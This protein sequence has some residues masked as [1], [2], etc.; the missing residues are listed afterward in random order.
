[1]AIT[2]RQFIE[3]AA[4]SGVPA[5]LAVT[6][7][8]AQA[9]AVSFSVPNVGRG[10]RAIVVGAGISGLI[11]ALELGRA[12]FSCTIVEASDRIGGRVL[13][14]RGGDQV[15]E[16]GPVQIAQWGRK[17]HLYFNAGASRIS[18]SHHT[19]LDYC[20]QLGVRIRPFVSDNR[21]ALAHDPALGNGRPVAI[22]RIAAD[23][24][25]HVAALA[26][27]MARSRNAGAPSSAAER[28]RLIELLGVFGGLT[29]EGT[30]AGSRRAGYRVPPRAGYPGEAELPIALEDLLQGQVWQEA[31]AL[32]ELHE[33]ASPMFEPEGGMDALPLAFLPHLPPVVLGTQCL[34]IE[35]R[36]EGGLLVTV[37]GS[38]THRLDTMEAD[39]VLATV[40]LTAL[41]RMDHDFGD[42]WRR[43][44]GSAQ[45]APAVRAGFYCRTRFWEAKGI[46]G[47][48]SRTA[49]PISEIGYPSS[50][51]FEL[52][53]ILAAAHVRGGE[54]GSQLS[55][56]APTDRHAS[57]M[58]QV[59]QV[60]PECRSHLVS[61]VSV[62]WRNV[63]DIGGAWMDWNAYS[64]T[65]EV[66]RFL[67][68]RW[69][70]FFAGDHL[71]ALPG[72]MEGAA[73]SAQAAVVAITDQASRS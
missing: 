60:H 16:A 27:T 6:G 15:P 57:I 34:K 36:R 68:H 64:G 29:E 30:Y 37:R 67:E 14:L 73:L 13:T 49:L 58:R 11:G 17:E 19:V 66:A 23:L 65:D 33:Y 62:A 20:R 3:T 32:P 70:Y 61:G 28:A 46:Y 42:H 38:R 39:C 47:G 41:A 50:G 21:A 18:H 52:D 54:A 72:W 1:M 53:G 31:A 2:R 7:A 45:Y 63:P 10:R 8:G 71:S 43:L 40:P 59:E 48:Q 56:L 5:A 25:G 24:R 22:G 4:R 69:P 51:L 44:A 55:A 12:G 26:S 9:A 35:R